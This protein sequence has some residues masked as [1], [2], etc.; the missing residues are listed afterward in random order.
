MILR[1]C[2]PKGNISFRARGREREREIDRVTKRV[3]GGDLEKQIKVRMFIA[4][5]FGRPPFN[6]PRG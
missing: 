3:G 4:S 5:A 1:R 2:C 6:Y